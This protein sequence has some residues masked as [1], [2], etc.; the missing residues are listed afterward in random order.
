MSFQSIN[1]K[2][3][4]S[5]LSHSIIGSCFDVQ[6]SL[7]SG[8]PEKTYQKALAYELHSRKINFS[9]QVVTD[10]KYK[11][12]RI[13]NRRFEFLVD[14]KII[15]ELKVGNFLGKSEF[16]Q[17]FEYLQMSGIK[18]GL[19]ILFSTSG[20]KIKRIINLES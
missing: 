7:G 6:N 5:E 2:Y 16:E 13:G 17:I 11:D 1:S 18:L 20:V 3:I 4:Y 10:L 8:R 12:I 9:E 19:L 15:V 14:N